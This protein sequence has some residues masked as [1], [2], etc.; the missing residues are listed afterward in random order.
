MKPSLNARVME[1]RTSTSVDGVGKVVRLVINIAGDNWQAFENAGFNL[2]LE[3]GALSGELLWSESA[4]AVPFENTFDVRLLIACPEEGASQFQQEAIALKEG[5][6]VT[7]GEPV[8][9]PFYAPINARGKLILIA[10]GCDVDIFRPLVKKIYDR[11]IEWM[12]EVRAYT[13]DDTGI[14]QIY[15]NNKNADAMHY[16]DDSGFRAF[17]ALMAR[18]SATVARLESVSSEQAIVEFARFIRSPSTYVYVAGDEAVIER[19]GEAVDSQLGQPGVWE[20]IRNSLVT[21]NHWYSY[22]FK[23]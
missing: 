12:G 17:D 20:R 2:A 9:Y 15:L 22:F 16:L 11:D 13:G 1:A 4:Y 18:S 8:A 3:S 6:T 7:L 10:A 5:D 21:Q 23:G 19:L 14:D